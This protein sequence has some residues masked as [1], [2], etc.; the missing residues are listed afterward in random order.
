ALVRALADA[1]E[2]DRRESARRA[3]ETLATRV[4]TGEIAGPRLEA[5]RAGLEPSLRTILEGPRDAPLYRD[6]VL[7]AASWRDRAALET[8]AALLKTAG[9][10]PDQGL[11]ALD[12][13]VAA[14]DRRAL[15]AAS[16]TLAT[17][18]P[19]RAERRARVLATLG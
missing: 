7:L 18:G 8:A 3:F 16:R 19:G 2:P 9:L 10:P 1:G 6:A 17:R 14:G 5:L 13:L 12:A 15:D 4:Q 11:R